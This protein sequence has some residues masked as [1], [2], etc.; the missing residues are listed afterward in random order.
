MIDAPKLEY[1]YIEDKQEHECCDYSFTNKPSSLVEAYIDTNTDS[2]NKIV[3]NISA[4]K[5]LTLT[6]PT[7]RVRLLVHHKFNQFKIFGYVH[8]S[9]YYD[10]ILLRIKNTPNE[11]RTF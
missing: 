10:M 9:I 3:T 5:V 2:V 1:L 8:S 7:I 6:F 4:V 11:Q